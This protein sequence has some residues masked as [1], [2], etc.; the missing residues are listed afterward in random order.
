MGSRIKL[1]N[2]VLFITLRIFSVTGGIEKVC[3]LAGKALY[4]LGMQYGGLIKIHSMYGPKGKADG[5]KYFPQL[6]FTGFSGHRINCVLKSIREGRRSR[7][8]LLSHI[9]LLIIGY[10]IK[11]IKPSVKLVMLAHGIEV[12]YPLSSWK[13]KML[14][15]CDLILPVSHFTRDKLISQHG[16]PKERLVVI[17]NCLDPF[18]EQ[19]LNKEKSP[20]LMNRYGLKG[21]ETILLTVS[22]IGNTERDKGYD[23]VLQA[24]PELIAENPGIRYLMVGNYTVKEKQRLNELIRQLGL[25]QVVIFTG[26]IPDE[27]MATHFKLSDIFV[28]P[29]RKEGFGI[30]FI[31]AMFY[32]LPVI[33]GNKDGSTDALCNGELGILVDPNDVNGLVKAV[34]EVMANRSRYVPDN[35]KLMQHFGYTG[36]KQQLDHCL[37]NLLQEAHL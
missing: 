32:G 28:M 12:W 15:K 13:K 25:E 9:N 33:G 10:L 4:E 19:P 14:H 34:E 29:S 21:N 2:K 5:N 36:Y 35:N 23:K 6:I 1:K 7:V 27:L 20:A 17:N 18:M 3:K 26:I 11:L 30:V 8:V 24:L 31:E 16:I 37:N 22:R